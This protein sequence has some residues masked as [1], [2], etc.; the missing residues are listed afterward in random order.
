MR[1]GP[2]ELSEGK[3]FWP[4]QR[5]IYETHLSWGERGYYKTF[6]HWETVDFFDTKEEAHEFIKVQDE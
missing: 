2:P 4:V 6:S 3:K 1:I 5:D